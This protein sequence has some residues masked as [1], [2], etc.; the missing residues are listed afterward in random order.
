MFEQRIN[1]GAEANDLAPHPQLKLTIA[2]VNDRDGDVEG[3]GADFYAKVWFNDSLA[4]N[5]AVFANNRSTI[6]PNWEFTGSYPLSHFPTTIRIS[7]QIFDQDTVFDDQVDINP[8]RGETLNLYLDTTLK[9]ITG[10]GIKGF[11]NTGE[12]ITIG[13]DD[14]GDDAEITFKVEWG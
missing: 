3:N 1:V 10:D 7:I 4:G 6:S 14:T 12:W 5:T 11:R 8:N 9:R 2:Q 13:E